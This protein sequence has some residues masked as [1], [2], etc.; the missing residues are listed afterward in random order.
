MGASPLWWCGPHLEG[1][2]LG[3]MCDDVGWVG[4]SVGCF[5]MCLGV[6]FP[7]AQLCVLVC[8]VACEL[9]AARRDAR[10]RSWMMRMTCGCDWEF[11]KQKMTDF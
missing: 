5:G 2:C 3:M 1:N 6:V 9:R 11:K 8:R 4:M 10:G 7:L